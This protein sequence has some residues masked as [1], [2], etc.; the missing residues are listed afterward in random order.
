[1][2]NVPWWLVLLIFAVV[3]PL[4]F[5]LIFEGR[6]R[7]AQEKAVRRGLET[8][9]VCPNCRG[10]MEPGTVSSRY[11]YMMFKGRGKKRHIGAAR[12]VK[13]GYTMFFS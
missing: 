11:A 1:M 2:N 9:I 10:Q 5:G 4:F 6:V 3:V 13:C 7:G 8:V 12:C